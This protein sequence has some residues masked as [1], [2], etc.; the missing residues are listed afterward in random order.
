[1]A[2]D[3]VVRVALEYSGQNGTPVVNIL[4]YKQTSDAFLD[5]DLAGLSAFAGDVAN[6]QTHFLGFA[7]TY[8]TG[9]Q[10][11]A[12]VLSGGAAGLQAVDLTVAGISGTTGG[13]DGPVERCVVFSLRSLQVGRKFR[14][15][16]F[17]PAPSGGTFT[18]DGAYAPAGPDHAKI[19]AAEA[20]LLALRQGPASACMQ[21][22]IFHRT[23]TVNTST[24]VVSAGVSLK[25]GTQRRRKLS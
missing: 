7:S 3:D 8:I 16:V 14:G 17:S 15:R 12:T 20:Q 5:F 18:L 4:H 9:V 6:V 25:V 21:L 19:T 23:A 1:M 13:T 11:T 2:L 22:C 24:T 10:T